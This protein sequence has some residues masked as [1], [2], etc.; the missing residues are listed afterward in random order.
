MISTLKAGD[1]VVF[2]ARILHCGNAN[3]SATTR[4]LFNFSFRRPDSGVLGY[5][6]SI[7]KGYVSQTTLG[8]LLQVA[9]SLNGWGGGSDG[10]TLESVYGN[11]L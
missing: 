5:E 2:D 10:K 8:E 6:G 3:S 11:G 9:D 7:R 4:A 1:A